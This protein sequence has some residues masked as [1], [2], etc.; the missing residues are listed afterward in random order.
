[1]NIKQAKDALK[2]GYG[3]DRPVLFLSS[4]GIGKSQAVMQCATELGGDFDCSFGMIEIRGASSSPSELATVK[5]IDAGTVLDAEQGWVP[6]DE[7]VKAGE[8]PERG[9]IFCDELPDSMMS[10]QSTLQRLFLDKKL[11]GLT[12]AKKW[13]VVA[14]GN[15]AKDK[16]ASGRISRALI[17]RC[18][19]IT[20]LPDPD[21]FYDW[22]LDNG[23]DYRVLA[24]VRFK[25][26]CVSDGLEI[27][28]SEN[29]AF[30]SP[31]SLEIASDVIKSEMKLDRAVEMELITGVLGDGRGSEFNGFMDI[32]DDLPD[33][34]ELLKDP[35][36]YPVPDKI[37][38]AWATIGAVTNRATRSNVGDIMKFF[39]RMGTELSVIAVQDLA[40]RE[41]S[42]MRTKEFRAW[43]SNVIK[44]AV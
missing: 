1:M 27:T 14:A 42:C 38:V 15:R 9:I 12:L 36:N 10:V 3:I 11:G 19:V 40:K 37:N 33:I 13:Y 17:N 7:R 30:C 18:M 41:K 16:A 20:V 39:M 43:S 24:Y 8:C 31:R 35:E 44:F 22:G 4:P 26:D 5:Y 25:P 34:D 2:L 28:R 23:I 32:M 6:T 29:Q 21:V